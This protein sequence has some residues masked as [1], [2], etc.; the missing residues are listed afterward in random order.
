MPSRAGRSEPAR[1]PPRSTL[2]PP[3]AGL[4]PRSQGGRIGKLG[5]LRAAR[6]H[7]SHFRLGLLEFREALP[8]PLRLVFLTELFEGARQLVMWTW[9]CGLERDGAL[10][11][12]NGSLGVAPEKQSF[13]KIVGYVGVG[14]VKLRCFLQVGGRF[15]PLAGFHQA[16]AELIKSVQTFR[17]AQ[18]LLFV[19]GDGFRGTS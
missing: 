6:G 19:F 9:I 17:R 11:R 12:G 4:Q 3:P 10:Q 5:S 7:A 15:P 14:R 13:A 8:F 16:V 18:Q 2:W 1:K